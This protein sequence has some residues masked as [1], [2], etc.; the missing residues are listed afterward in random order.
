MVYSGEIWAYERQGRKHE[1]DTNSHP[2]CGAYGSAIR[3]SY[4]ATLDYMVAIYSVLSTEYMHP[5]EGIC[6]ASSNSKCQKGRFRSHE[7]PKI[8]IQ[9][10]C[11][12]TLRKREKKI[13]TQGDCS[14]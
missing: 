6:D 5:P 1:E 10:E 13:F 4:V 14:Q 3:L 2:T 7:F 9:Q 11:T 12:T 8:Q